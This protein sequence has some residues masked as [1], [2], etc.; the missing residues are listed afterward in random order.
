MNAAQIRAM[1]EQRQN[2]ANELRALYEGAADRDLTAEERQAE[3]RL[4]GALD[5]LMGRIDGGLA[6]I[7]RSQKADEARAR[8]EAIEARGADAGKGDEAETGDLALLRKLVNG[9]VR[10]VDFGFERRDLTKGTATAGGHT[11]PSTLFGQ[12]YVPM[13]EFATVMRDGNARILT[14]AG[15]EDIPMPVVSSFPAAAL[16]AEGGTITESDPAFAQVTLKAYK[17]AHMTQVSSELE[18]DSIVDLQSLLAD[19]GGQALGRGMGGYF[20]TGTGSSQPK[21]ITGTTNAN[22]KTAA[23]ATAIT[24]AELMDVQHGVA[25]PYRA[26]ARWVMKDS[27]VK[28]IRKLTDSDGQFLWAAGLQVGTPDTLLGSPVTPDDG[29]AAIATGAISVV[30]GDFRAGY[31]VRL[32]GGVRIERSTEY[33]FN[34]DLVSYRFIVRADGNI[35]DNSAIVKLTQ[36]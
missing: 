8:L 30:Y 14:T 5:D 9:E 2:A 29:M 28:Y 19:L 27:T 31:V 12:L 4:N 33:A 26:N 32:A 20:I 21:G 3:E 1:F 23:G 34:T 7:E 18:Q 16:I 35:I 25:T 15:G 13:R 17:F 24:A 10:A 6:D 11:V 22:N 36:A